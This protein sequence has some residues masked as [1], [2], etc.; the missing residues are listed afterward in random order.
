MG[1]F[2]W[3]DGMSVGVVEFDEDHKRCIALLEDV[4]AAVEAGSLSL[5]AE[6]CAALVQF[7]TDHCRR[8]EAFLRRIGYSGID[9][10][11]AVQNA[12]VERLRKISLGMSEHPQAVA[13]LAADMRSAL[14]DYLL[15]GDINYKSYVDYVGA[16]DLPAKDG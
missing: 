11:I 2:H 8:E 4:E 10:L 3:I 12:N 14:V 13:Q 5:A 1:N 9:D 15:R 16:S 7:M 6:L